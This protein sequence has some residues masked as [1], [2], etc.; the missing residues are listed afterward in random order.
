VKVAFLVLV[1]DAATAAGGLFHAGYFARYWLR[2]SERRAKRTG[3]AAL[4]C[5]GVAG[6]VEAAFS[7][8]LLYQHDRLVALG[9]LSEGIW[10]LARLPLLL[11][12]AFITAII[13]RRI[14]S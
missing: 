1:E 12:T 5:L 14:F 13:V 4:V 9:G 3:A 7:Q 2:A 10:A 6:A 11:A 8:G